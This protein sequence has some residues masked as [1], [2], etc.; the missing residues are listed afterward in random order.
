MAAHEEQE[1]ST[2]KI[3]RLYG[4]DN[5]TKWKVLFEAAVCYND[6][7]MWN[8]IKNGPQAAAVVAE[9]ANPNANAALR[10]RM[11]KVDD[12]ALA[13]L[14]LGLSWDILTKVA[15]HQT[16][17]QMY[18]A[19]LEMYEGNEE[20]KEIKKARLKQQLERFNYK[21]GER[22]KSILERFF[23]IVNEIRTTNLA[24]TDL[25]LNNKLL[26][27]MPKEWYTACKFILTKPNYKEL[28]L[29]DV[30]CFLQAS[31]IEMIDNE[32]IREESPSFTVSNALIAPMGNL[33]TKNHQQ[34]PIIEEPS[35][36]HNDNTKSF[37][38]VGTSGGGS[39]PGM[40]RQQNVPKS[41]GF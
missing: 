27:S 31:E 33:S 3:P 26:S 10:E 24:V 20:L 32:M 40:A 23:S 11:R 21:S 29:D 22:L 18:D 12:R 25:E 38:G 5:F 14:K 7:D 41:R 39:Q 19:I 30:V 4:H 2:N 8:S 36:H 37:V 35:E 16:A 13:M 17:K 34:I 6:V 15:H 1:V 28:K 9:G